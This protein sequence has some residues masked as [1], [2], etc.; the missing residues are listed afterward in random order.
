[1][2]DAVMGRQQQGRRLLAGT[3][4]SSLAHVGLVGALVVLPA[5]TPT[6]QKP[7]DPPLVMLLPPRGGP[8]PGNSHRT[9]E[10][11]PAAQQ[12]R[13]KPPRTLV[14]P[15][16]VP[17]PLVDAPTAPPVLEDDAPSTDAA[18]ASDDAAIGPPGPGGDGGPHVG[19]GAGGREVDYEFGPG[20]TRPVRLSGDD[21]RYTRDALTAEVEGMLIVKCV[22]ATSGVLEDCRVLKGLPYMDGAVLSAFATHRYAPAT[23]QG[24]PVRVG[25]VFNVRLRLPR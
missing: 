19:E 18:S 17:P 2:F 24:Q 16:A 9:P 25:Y 15:R 1:M 20:M 3:V 11:K 21:P 22:V 23:F 4:L 13:T 14:A 12:R 6:T 10:A 8:A 5:L 7:P